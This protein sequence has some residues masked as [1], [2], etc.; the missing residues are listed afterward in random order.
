M[1]AETHAFKLAESVDIKQVSQLYRQLTEKI[2]QSD[3]LTIDGSEVQLMDTAGL[4]L[5]LVFQLECSRQNKKF[6]LVNPSSFIICLV[7]SLG[8]NLDFIKT[9]ER[10]EASS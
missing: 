1:D 9:S 4:Q 8:V 3:T 7:K 10:I 2:E 6:Q 5:L